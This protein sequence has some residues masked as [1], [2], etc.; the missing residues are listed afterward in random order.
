MI[1]IDWHMW[2]FAYS[3]EKKKPAFF[4]SHMLLQSLINMTIFLLDLSR[5]DSLLC[6]FFSDVHQLILVLLVRHSTLLCSVFCNTTTTTDC[7]AEIIFLAHRNVWR[8]CA[9]VKFSSSLDKAIGMKNR[10]R[11]I[12]KCSAKG[13]VNI[14]LV[15]GSLSL[16]I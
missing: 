16:Q 8:N 12:D 5:Y 2:R 14:V 6:S 7:A 15:K 1:A 4:K 11:H 9:P 10:S 13:R 3:P